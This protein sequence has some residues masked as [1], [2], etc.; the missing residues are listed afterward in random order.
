MGNHSRRALE[1]AHSGTEETLRGHGGRGQ[2]TLSGG[3][4]EVQELHFSCAA[5]ANAPAALPL[6]AATRPVGAYLPTTTA[7]GATTAGPASPAAAIPGVRAGS[8]TGT[9]GT[10]AGGAAGGAAA[11]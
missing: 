6:R 1:S 2:D 11:G 10:T 8:A 5:P 7:R 9:T 3:D 4:G